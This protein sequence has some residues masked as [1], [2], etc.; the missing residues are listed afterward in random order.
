MYKR[1]ISK[2]QTIKNT[3]N[4]VQ[5]QQKDFFAIYIDKKNHVKDIQKKSNI[6]RN[7]KQYKKTIENETKKCI[8]KKNT[9]QSQLTKHR[10]AILKAT[11]Y[12]VLVYSQ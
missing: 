10:Q 6:K 8:Q 4:I 1:N 11:V 3:I 12:L 2:K 7:T 5:D 9:K